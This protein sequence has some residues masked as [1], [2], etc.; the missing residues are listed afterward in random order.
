MK[1]DD[2]DSKNKEQ[3]ELKEQDRKT[4]SGIATG[5]I[6][7]GSGALIHRLGKSLNKPSETNPDTHA[8]R[9]RPFVEKFGKDDSIKK[10]DK[11]SRH[12][13]SAGLV[14]AGAGAAVTGYSA[15]RHFKD[16]K[17]KKDEDTKK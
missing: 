3:E 2:I 6:G 7:I 9:L 11:S 15:Y 17:K 16:K 12:L 14:L 13:K 4:K 1:K 5:I 8:G 10:L